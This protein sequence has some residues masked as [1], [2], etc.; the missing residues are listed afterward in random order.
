MR[1][2]EYLDGVPVALAREND[3]QRILEGDLTMRFTAD[4]VA[5]RL[6]QAIP[7][8]VESPASSRLWHAAP[9]AAL[10]TAMR[11]ACSWT[12]ARTA[13]PIVSAHGL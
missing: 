4:C 13:R 12:C 1:T 2:V 10:D 8:S 3:R 5:E 6:K 11:R 9:I 7:V